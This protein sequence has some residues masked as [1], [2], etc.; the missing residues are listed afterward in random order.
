M[1]KKPKRVS[2]AVINQLKRISTPTITTQL[3]STHGLYNVSPRNAPPIDPSL[4]AFAGPTYI[5]CYILLRED[6][7]AK[8]YLDHPENLMTRAVEEI[9][10]GSVMVMDSNGRH[11]VGI[12]GGNILMR[13][14]MRKIVGVVA[15]GGM[16]DIPG[17]KELG[18][19]VCCNGSA[20]PPS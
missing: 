20:L 10:A 8:Q 6:L 12:Q 3:M 15:V 1:A 16:R 13:L 4:D 9:L 11:D 17:I 7:H 19:P 18:L 5:L 14:K 2:K